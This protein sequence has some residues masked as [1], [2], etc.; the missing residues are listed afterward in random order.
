M[1]EFSEI[2]NRYDHQVQGLV[3]LLD[4][5]HTERVKAIW[6][7]LETECGLTAIYETPFPHFS[8]HIAERYNLK[9]LDQ[10]ISTVIDSIRPFTIRTTGISMF[11]GQSPVVFLPV[12]ATQELLSIHKLLWEHT[13]TTSERLSHYYRPGSWVPHITLANKDVTPKNLNCVTSQLSGQ[14]FTWE[15]EI[16]R[17]GVICQEGGHADIHQVYPLGGT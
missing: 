16:D 10:Q 6:Q 11:T 2:T 1:A 8:F 3:A 14:P 15:I 12:V 17:F 7:Q 9:G 4:E 13:T 5:T